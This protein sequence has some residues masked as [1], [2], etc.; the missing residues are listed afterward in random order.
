M[1]AGAAIAIEA[2]ILTYRR[3][4][5]KNVV[6]TTHHPIVEPYHHDDR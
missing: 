3:A 4:R 5:R 1:L 6:E 2:V